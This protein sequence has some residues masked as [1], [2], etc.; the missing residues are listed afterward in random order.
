MGGQRCR[1]RQ[2][3]EMIQVTARRQASDSYHYLMSVARNQPKDLLHFAN[4]TAGYLGGLVYPHVPTTV[5]NGGIMPHVGSPNDLTAADQE[6]AL[7]A[8]QLFLGLHA[9]LGIAHGSRPREFVCVST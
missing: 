7:E 2:Q 1:Q 8:K 6:L 4:R 3:P 5:M 9:N